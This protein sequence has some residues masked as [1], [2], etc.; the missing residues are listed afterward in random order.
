M[1]ERPPTSAIGAVAVYSAARLVV[2]VAVAAALYLAGLRNALLVLVALLGSG[3]VSYVLLAPQRA[4]MA[5]VLSRGRR[6]P[7]RPRGSL[8]ARIAASAAAEDAHLDSLAE[9]PPDVTGTN[10]TGGHRED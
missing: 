2:F 9:R 8:S 10:R 5:A 7:R 6:R 1:T 3:L 4:A